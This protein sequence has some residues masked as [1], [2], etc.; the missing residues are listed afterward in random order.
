MKS[1]LKY[2]FLFCLLISGFISSA[3]LTVSGKISDG[4]TGAALQGA[5][6]SI[7]KLRITATSNIIG[8][9]QLNNI[10]QGQYEIKVS[11]VG[12][13]DTSAIVVINNIALIQDFQMFTS[14]VK[15]P[16]VIVAAT[17]TEKLV[18]DI[19]AD[20]GIITQEQIQNLPAISTDEYL[21]SIPGVDAVRHFGIFDKT[22]DVYMRGLDRN[23]HTLLLIN[24]A[25]M[26]ILDGGATNWNRIKPEDIE[27]LKLSKV[28]IL[29]STE[30]MQWAV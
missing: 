7:N 13:R 5:T 25:P 28:L 21:N 22:G 10:P 19:P 24:G 16:S 4:V 6:I 20:I 17:R 8:E 14:L 2:Y 11:F 3:Q 1:A 27:K 30:A 9:Y 23:V 26:S 29:L 15:M 18:K 12:Y